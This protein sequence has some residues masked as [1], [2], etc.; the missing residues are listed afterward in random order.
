VLDGAYADAADERCEL[1]VLIVKGQRSK[2]LF[3]PVRPR[4][5]RFSGS[6]DELGHTDEVNSLACPPRVF[7]V[8]KGHSTS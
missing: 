3:D 7:R 5:K 6:R 2:V 8:L 4:L 1:M